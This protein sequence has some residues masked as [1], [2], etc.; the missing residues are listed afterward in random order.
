MTP[1]AVIRKILSDLS[2]PA[3]FRRDWY[4][5]ATNQLA[6]ITLGVIL[7]ALLSFANFMTIGEFAYKGILFA[8]VAVLF[9]AQQGKQWTLK[10]WDTFEDFVFTVVYGAGTVIIMFDEVEPGSPLIQTNIINIAPICAIVATHLFV[11]SVIRAA[12]EVKYGTDQH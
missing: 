8:M 2:T 5:W 3:S 9:A 7:A 11:G 10:P 4:G 12:R 6:H 1:S